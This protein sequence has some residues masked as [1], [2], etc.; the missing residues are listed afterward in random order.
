MFIII[1]RFT[2]TIAFTKNLT[3]IENLTKKLFKL[4]VERPVLEIVYSLP[5]FMSRFT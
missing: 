2:P 1:R 4:P 5:G 3:K